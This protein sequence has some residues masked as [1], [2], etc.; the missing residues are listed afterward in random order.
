MGIWWGMHIGE[1]TW[2]TG[3]NLGASTAEAIRYIDFIAENN[4][5]GLLI[6]GWNI[7]WD[8]NWIENGPIFKSS[9]I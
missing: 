7:G 9:N 3:P 6:E 2:S 5:D 8:G 4:I 1:N